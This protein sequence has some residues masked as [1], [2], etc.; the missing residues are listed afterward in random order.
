MSIEF[1]QYAAEYSHL[2]ADPVRDFFAGNHLF[3]HR[4]KWMLIQDFFARQKV[5]CSR[6]SWLDVG[7][8]Q[9]DLLRLAGANFARAVG[10]DPSGGMIQSCG[11]AR[12]CEQPSAA[13][14]PFPDNSFDFV[15]AVCVY[16]HVHGEDRALLTRSIHRV[17]RPGG[18]FGMIEHN[19]WNPI[20][21]VIVKRCP[22]DSDAELL[23]ASDAT[24][25]AAAVDLQIVE[26]DYFLYFPENVFERFGRVERALRKLPFGGQFAT[27]W[28]KSDGP[29]S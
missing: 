18:I 11:S 19:P 16:H 2:L 6:L 28:R 5:D 10:C 25:L 26:T 22:V 1:D 29:K 17:L 8:G 13:E 27:F 3:F 23:T 7:C 4:R 20:T 24:R 15:T 14:L 12:V 9:G 21:Q